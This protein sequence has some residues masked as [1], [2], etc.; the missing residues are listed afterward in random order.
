MRDIRASILAGGFT[1]LYRK[2]RAFLSEAD[3]ENPIV[4]MKR[5]KPRTMKLG[6]YEVHIARE[7]F[8]SIRQ[9]SSGEIMHMRTPPMEE[10]RQLYVEQS[11]LAERLRES[12]AEPLIIWDVGLGAGANA[13]AAIECYEEQ[14]TLGPVRPL[15]IVSFEND[16]N[17]LK[18]AFQTN[19]LFPYLR[20]GGPA[21]ILQHGEWQSKHHPGLTWILLRGDFIAMIPQASA[22]PDLIF[23]DMFSSKACAEAWT[24][25]S[26]QQL[27]GACA[28]RAVEL[29]TYTCSTSVRVTLLG[30][31][32]YLARGRAVGPKEETTIALT[33][34]A[35]RLSWVGRSEM[36]SADW[37]ARWERSG[38]KFPPGLK[39]AAETAFE[40]RI[41]GHE[42]FRCREALK[43]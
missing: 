36:L 42:Q 13:M 22:P 5:N 16:L 33:P 41:R 7:G 6:D 9:I 4:P 35:Y 20:H 23:Y 19:D 1:E 38:A 32:F 12:V 31:G 26:F 15:Q 37:L 29:F 18:L 43:S 11:R 2:K 8:A 14:A 40:D 34:Q 10:A 30:A 21:A 25:T 17:S 39:P 28:G 27:F 24:M 3:L